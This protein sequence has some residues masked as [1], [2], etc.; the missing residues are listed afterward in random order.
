MKATFK[1]TPNPDV[2]LELT[3]EEAEVVLILA[4]SCIGN[5]SDSRREISDRIYYA[6][7]GLGM[8]YPSHDKPRDFSG[9][10]V[11]TKV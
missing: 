6:L 3:Y 9:Q 5:S 2:T 11:F 7:T 1:T 4:G 10:V 8:K